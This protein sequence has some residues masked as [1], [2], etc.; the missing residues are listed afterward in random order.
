M[1]RTKKH[2]SNTKNKKQL[3][4]I[5]CFIGA[6]VI[7]VLL[8]FL[9]YYNEYID[10]T[11][12]SERLKQMQA[13]TGQLFHEIEN[14]LD[15]KWQVVESQCNYLNSSAPKTAS[16][17]QS[18]MNR[19]EALNGFDQNSIEIFAVDRSGRC[20]TKNGWQSTLEN[21]DYLKSNPPQAA[22]ISQQLVKG[23]TNMC[24]VQR[25]NTPV[26]I[27]GDGQ[28]TQL[29]YFGILQ[30][31]TELN[32]YFLCSAYDNCN[33]VYVLNSHGEMVFHS[34]KEDLLKSQNILTALESMDYL[35]GTSFKEAKE[36]FESNG[37]AYS[38]AIL[39][40]EEYYYALNK[41]ENID[42]DVAFLVPASKVA[43]DIVVLVNTVFWFIL[44][45]TVIL[46]TACIF[47][48]IS[49][50]QYKDRQAV[51]AERKNTEALRA[52]NKELSNAIITKER[53]TLTA[54]FANKSKSR[55]L[56]NMSHDIRTP[57]NAIVGIANI[58]SYQNS[59]SEQMADYI[60]KLQSSG[61]HLL[62]LINNV[63][64]MSSIEAG[65]FDL[66]E[67]PICVADYVQQIESIIRVQ[68]EE[69]QQTLHLEANGIQHEFLI[70]DGTHIQQI[71]INLLSNA[72]KYTQPG[73][74]IWFTVTEKPAAAPNTATFCFTVSDNGY[75]MTADF[76]KHV[77]EPF[78]RAQ[79]ASTAHTTGTGLGLAIAKNLVELMQGEITVQSTL[80][81]GTTF[82]VTL[83]IGI[84]TNT[85][86]HPGVEQV[87][88]I[89][90]S[91]AFT[92][93]VACAFHSQPQ[94]LQTVPS[95]EQALTALKG[96]KSVAVL[97]PLKLADPDG[98]TVAALK[99][100]NR[101]CVVLYTGSTEEKQQ[102]SQQALSKADGFIAQP[103]FLSAF[104]TAVETAQKAGRATAENRAFL[105][106]GCH[107]LCAEDN[108]L[109]A[110]ILAATLEM[111]GGTCKIYQNGKKLTEA[112]ETVKPGEFTAIL[113]DIQMPDMDGYEAARAI[114][115]SN[116]PLGK[117]IPVIALTANAFNEDAQRCYAAGMDAHI[118]KPLQI[119]A[120]K[121]EL[122]VIEAKKTKAQ[123]QALL[124]EKLHVENEK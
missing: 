124:P 33:S 114:R 94:T 93:S 85:V 105:L 26:E 71:L 21:M 64:D 51:E 98:A 57:I 8:V 6:V 69:K 1:K 47:G 103:F 67:E 36:Q 35:H 40:G 61:D 116:N 56:A 38:N 28:K 37:I 58:M 59:I 96:Q 73:G 84:D 72:T 79:N 118:A 44:T 52:V 32:P 119:S 10:K 111:H 49:V 45:L 60:A 14:V 66:T 4:V 70:G 16:E 42:L 46:A 29:I 12:Y 13:V 90:N 50:L 17:L 25:L 122:Q 109:N 20:F 91:S 53:A 121:K 97:L 18:F 55:F 62:K 100:A 2:R 3:A 22:F 5:L 95:A 74:T 88:L 48:I 63:L 41:I 75:G 112:F 110:E 104:C 9:K 87:L 92:Q 24:F 76:V 106:K 34:G 115:H 123:Q 101:H 80:G 113:M 108:E 82:T 78:A 83:P 86:C 89:S 7:G 11:L 99:G 15:A 107:F 54:E 117:A 39:G 23:N 77:F 65:S 43:A 68:A 120:L 81:T 19:Q 27:S 102:L 30:S 31:M